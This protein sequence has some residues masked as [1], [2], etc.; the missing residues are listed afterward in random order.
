M[1]FYFNRVSF[2]IPRGRFL[3]K[4]SCRGAMA[5]FLHKYYLVIVSLSL[6]SIILAQTFPYLNNN[7]TYVLSWLRGESQSKSGFRGCFKG[8]LKASWSQC[9]FVLYVLETAFKISIFFRTN[10]IFVSRWLIDI[11]S[12]CQYNN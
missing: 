9:Y 3:S 4:Y 5:I 2:K 8:V 6:K 1:R 11:I 7:S 12:F 10:R